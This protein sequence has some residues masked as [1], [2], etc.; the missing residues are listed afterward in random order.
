MVLT[1]N[2]LCS[3]MLFL[4]LGMLPSSCAFNG[5]YELLVERKSGA[6]EHI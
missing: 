5:I 4:R 3:M 1:M 2:V 6:L